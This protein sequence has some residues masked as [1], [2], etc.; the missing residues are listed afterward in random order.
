MKPAGKMEG[1]KKICPICQ[2]EFWAM[3][4]WVYKK[5]YKGHPMTY[6]CSYKCIRK[7]T[8]ETDKEGKK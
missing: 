6:Y 8:E 2:K 1:Y 4:D 5:G 7:A 3:R